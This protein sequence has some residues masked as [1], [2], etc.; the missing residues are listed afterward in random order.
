MGGAAGGDKGLALVVV[1]LHAHS[2]GRAAAAVVGGAAAQAHDDLL[3]A[4]GSGGQNQLA[5]A[6]GGGLAGILAILH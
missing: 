2:G 1:E 6:V 4:L 3:H 5:H